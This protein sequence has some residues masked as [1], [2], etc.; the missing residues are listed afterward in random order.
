MLDL[1]YLVVL[2]PLI[3]FLHNAFLMKRIPH[4]FAGAI[5]T[6]AVLIPFLITLQIF[7]EFKPME[8]TFPHIVTLFPW[9]HIGNFHLDI[10][11]QVDQLSLYMALVITGIGSLIHLYSMGYMKGDSG[12]VRFFAYLN[13]F[14]FSMLN[15]VLSDNLVLTFL[16]WE[17]VGLCSYLLIGFEYEK[18]SAAAA[19][20]KAFV[21]N[22]IGDLGF[23]L[24]SGFLFW[25]TGSLKYSEI[26]TL[27]PG[28]AH[29]AD[30]TDL[31]ALFF[32]IAAMGK[33]AQVP[34]YVWLPDAMAG[35]TPVSALIH[36]ATMV[37]AGIFL[38][39]RLSIVF[40]A[41]P[42]TSLLIASVGAFTA[43]FAASIGT[44]QTD[45]KKILAYSTVSQLGF[46]FLAMGVGSYVAGLFH[47]MTHAFFKA[48][49]FLGAGSVIHILHHE[50]NIRK[51]GS[52]F[53]KAKITSITFLLGTLAIAGIP[54]FSG[55]FSKDL[56]LEKTFQYPIYG[57][58]LWTVGILA[59]FFTAFYMFRLVFVVFFGTDRTDTHGKKIH[60]SPLTMTLPL[61]LLA[62]GA[63]IVGFLQTPHFFLHIH[64]LE[65]YFEPILFP[66]K[67]YANTVGSA[68]TLQALGEGDD[69]KLAGFA[70]LMSL[71]GIGL[72]GFL[73]TDRNVEVKEEH[74][75]FRKILFHKYYVDEIYDF[76]FVRP[77]VSI[78]KIIAFTIDRYAIDGF[79]TGIARVLQGLAGILRRFQTGFVG[80]YALYI[81]LGSFFILLFLLVKGV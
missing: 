32:F 23:I 67:V 74:S 13:L 44:L 40:M 10:A 24:G 30:Y 31:I 2:F 36:A 75:G 27:V 29:F 16:G 1:I 51:M 39:A 58:F 12:Y 46:M 11:Y 45:I 35:P 50:Q 38:I 65:S 37:T 63:S 56:I 28:I 77:F 81:T 64:T 69:L 25:L 52:L 49:L 62:I 60:E 43:L 68:V 71:F 26:Q 55:F 72:A 41:A 53:S 18:N 6:L 78:S 80:D 34:L 4:R 8:R 76:L 22:R 14:V 21:L 59:A 70:I 20:M 66:G 57:T 15:L 33:S 5:G 9:I 47:L 48:L 7:F 42:H 73:Y 54:P 3:G 19:G 79:F 17:G 61:L